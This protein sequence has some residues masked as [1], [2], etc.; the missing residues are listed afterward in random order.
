[1]IA[2]ELITEV[3]RL[4]EHRMTTAQFSKIHHLAKDGQQES[5]AAAVT[6]FGKPYRNTRQEMSPL[7]SR[8]SF[9]AT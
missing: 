6:H 5:T 2:K 1:M 8:C 4:R 9:I 7:A 3:E